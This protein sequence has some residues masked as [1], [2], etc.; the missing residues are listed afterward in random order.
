MRR[1]ARLRQIGCR[2]HAACTEKLFSS[3][4]RAN[5]SCD[6]PVT[7]PLEEMRILQAEV[8]VELRLEHRRAV[9]LNAAA[10]VTRN[11]QLWHGNLM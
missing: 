5:G 1:T 6:L 3:L 10:H 11:G 9:E 7:V 2:I 4:K 8:Q